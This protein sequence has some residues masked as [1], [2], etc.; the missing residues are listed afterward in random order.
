MALYD[1]AYALPAD[2]PDALIADLINFE[3]TFTTPVL[4]APGRV[5]R[6]GVVSRAASGHEVIDGWQEIALQQVGDPYGYT[7]FSEL[8]TYVTAVHG[9]W[10]GADAEISI[11]VDNLAGTYTYYNV[12]AHF[13][14]LGQDYTHNE[15]NSAYVDNLTLRYTMLNTYTP[16]DAP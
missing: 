6:G 5:P 12:I 1:Y 14:V 16:S 10:D 7:L 15:M 9:G 11:R 3:T 13:P 8:S 4:F 2:S